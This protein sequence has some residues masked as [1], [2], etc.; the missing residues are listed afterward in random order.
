RFAVARLA[1]E[2]LVLPGFR[3]AGEEVPRTI[4][5]EAALRA[6]I[7]ARAATRVARRAVLVAGDDP[8]RVLDEGTLATFGAAVDVDAAVA[9]AIAA[10]VTEDPLARVERAAAAREGRID[11]ALPIAIDADV[12]RARLVRVKRVE[13][14]PPVAARLDL[15]AHDVIP[16]RDGRYVD[17]DGAIAAIARAADRAQQ[18]GD[19]IAVPIAHVAP[20]FTRA[21]LVG[22]DVHQVLAAYDTYFSRRG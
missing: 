3:V 18:D 16:E 19:A 9:Q 14:A 10:G 20:R 7:E 11:L 6:W 1:P 5:S 13:D 8:R 12:A 17:V 22:L 15:D 2:A 4:A 21:A